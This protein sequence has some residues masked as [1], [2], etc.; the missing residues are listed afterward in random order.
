MPTKPVLAP[1]IHPMH[2]EPEITLDKDVK[3]ALTMAH[4]KWG[5]LLIKY[6]THIP[7][8][9]ETKYEDMT[10]DQL[11]MSREFA[12]L[13]DIA[14]LLP[15]NI[16]QKELGRIGKWYQEKDMELFHK[17]HWSSCWL[18]GQLVH[19]EYKESVLMNS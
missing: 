8:V 1:H 12:R 9:M 10:T 18:M 3:D 6:K 5:Q 19:R 2:A 14:D 16:K 17:H 7:K 4:L 11:A 13:I 15:H